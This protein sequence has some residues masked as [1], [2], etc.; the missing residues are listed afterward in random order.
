MSDAID[1]MRRML[2]EAALLRDSQDLIAAVV[3]ERI[4]SILVDALLELDLEFIDPWALL[5][6]S[7]ALDVGTMPPAIEKP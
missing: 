4:V 2:S 7:E 6:R 3:G 1:G 5:A